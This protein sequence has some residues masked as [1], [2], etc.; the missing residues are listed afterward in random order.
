MINRIDDLK[1][2]R[3]DL[4]GEALTRKKSITKDLNF[5]E[6]I[7]FNIARALSVEFANVLKKNNP[8]LTD[9]Q[10]QLWENRS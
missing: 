7:K 10:N 3:V 6:R 1:L 2:N 4:Y 8:V 5:Q 9:T